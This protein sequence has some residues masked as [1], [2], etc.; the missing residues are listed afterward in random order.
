LLIVSILAV[1]FIQNLNA[2]HISV[3]SAPVSGNIGHLNGYVGIGTIQPQTQLHLYKDHG[4]KDSDFPT[5][6]L[7][8]A[9]Y[10]NEASNYW[11]IKNAGTLYFNFSES[12][13]T[14]ISRMLIDPQGRLA[15]G[16]EAPD[17]SAVLHLQS[18]DKGFLAPRMDT[19]QKENISEA[20]PGL[21]VYDTDLQAFSYKDAGQNKWEKLV[22]GAELDNFLSIEAFNNTAAGGLTDEDVKNWN[23]AFL[24]GNHT[25]AGYINQKDLE[26]FADTFIMSEQNMTLSSD[27]WTRPSR[28]V[29]ALQ[30]TIDRVAIGHYSP[31]AKLHVKSTGGTGMYIS[32]DNSSVHWPLLIR[33]NYSP[34]NTS[35]FL[36]SSRNIL[37][38]MRDNSG[39]IGVRLHSAGDSYFTGGDVSIGTT[40]PTAVFEVNKSINNYW[41]AKISNGGGNALGLLVKAGYGGSQSYNTPTIMQLSD[42]AGNVR[43]RVQSNGKVGIGTE[44]MGS[45]L[46]AVNGSIG[47]REIVVELSTWADYVFNPSYKLMPLTELEEFIAQN[48]HLPEIP[49]E[50]TIAE[51]GLNLGEMQKLQMQKIE[52]LTLYVIELKKENEDLKARIEKIEGNK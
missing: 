20:A 30:S 9:P 49:S 25:K 11:D 40:N 22:S 29:V 47:A 8:N 13:N 5:L 42:F 33:T 50:E 41:T 6:R 36:S 43:M 46:L 23:S 16:A 28:S 4:M 34:T 35:G 39:N 12:Q 26:I 24:W 10:N 18:H 15:L 32:S 52:E 14:S 45:H 44:T 51:N 31:S 48:K 21:L 38:Y 2:Q 7:Q 37:L 19:G 27:L 17:P 3:R 1:F